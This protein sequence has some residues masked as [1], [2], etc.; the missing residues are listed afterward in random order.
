MDDHHRHVQVLLVDTEDVQ[1]LLVLA[2]RLA[3]VADDHQQGGL[4]QV[5]GFE[6]F[7]NAADQPVRLPDGVEIALRSCQCQADQPSENAR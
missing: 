3:M 7:P 1:P 6:P 4:R 5:P 2:E